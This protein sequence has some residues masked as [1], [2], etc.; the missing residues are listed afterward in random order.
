MDKDKIIEL[1][2][3]LFSAKIK[4]PVAASIMAEI[5]GV[6]IDLKP[7]MLGGF[8]EKEFNNYKDEDLDKILHELGLECV[9]SEH[10]YNVNGEEKV[11]KDFYVSKKKKLAEKTHQSFVELWPTI[12]D[13]GEIIDHKKWA[14]ATTKIGK[15]LGY[16]KTAIKEFVEERDIENEDRMKRM[17]RNRYY[18]HS[19]KYEEKEFRQY[20]LK[21][22]KAISEFAPK[23]T[24][25]WIE[26]KEKRWLK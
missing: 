10:L 16:P 15:L 24:A 5:I 22:N 1:E 2:N 17:E 14:K 13:N 7:A 3:Y 23:T 19:A 9:H 8:T 11:C 25:I 12:D 26:D 20:D 21:L 6:L 4:P 18:A